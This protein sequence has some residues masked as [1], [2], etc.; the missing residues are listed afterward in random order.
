MENISVAFFLTFIAG[1]ATSLG[2]VVPFFIRSN[3]KK[4]LSLVMGFSAG[5]LI[6]LALAGLLHESHESLEAVYGAEKGGLVSV[7]AFFAGILLISIADHFSGSCHS[8][9]HSHK[10]HEGEK[11]GSEA[12][13]ERHSY[14]EKLLRTGLFTAITLSIHNLPEGFAI[15]MSALKEPAMAVPMTIAVA[16]HNVPVGIAIAVPVFFATRRK[17]KAFL[18]AFLTGLTELVGAVLGY[19]V[20]APY[21][22]EKLFGIV[23]AV[24]AGI[25]IFLSFD[26]LLPVSREY[27]DQ[28]TSLYGLLAGMAVMAV[29]L[30]FAH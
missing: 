24:A 14:N 11:H 3:G 20:F 23:F 19:L 27:G 5:V 30:V 6:Y 10:H 2:A 9:H 13:M 22:S 8:F 12:H 4:I 26:E 16:V 25:M 15:F 17:R 18:Y 28:H 1:M 21:L 29:T 7:A